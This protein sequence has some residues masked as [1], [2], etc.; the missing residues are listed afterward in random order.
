ML[1]QSTTGLEIKA[2]LFSGNK[3]PLP[4][5]RY[6]S[7]NNYLLVFSASLHGPTWSLP[8]AKCKA[9]LF[10]RNKNLL[11]SNVDHSS[12]PNY[13]N[14][15]D[16]LHSWCEQHISGNSY[17]NGQEEESSLVDVLSPQWPSQP[18]HK[19]LIAKILK[20]DSFPGKTRVLLWDSTGRT[21][22]TADR[23]SLS[24]HYH[25]Y[26]ATGYI[27]PLFAWKRHSEPV[28]EV[29]PNS[30]IKISGFVR[31]ESY[32]EVELSTTD[33]QFKFE[34]LDDSDARIQDRNVTAPTVPSAPL[35]AHS[36]AYAYPT[37][38]IDHQVGFQPPLPGQEMHM[39]FSQEIAVSTRISVNCPEDSPI[40]TLDD[41][42]QSGP[43]E[44]FLIQATLVTILPLPS[45]LDS[46]H[47]LLPYCHNCTH[48]TASHRPGCAGASSDFSPRFR[49]I[50]S[51]S[52]QILSVEICGS[53]AWGFF[54]L[55]QEEFDPT[56]YAN[57]ILELEKEIGKQSK[58]LV[59]R[60]TD[61]IS[62]Q[63]T[64][65][66]FGTVFKP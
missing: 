42:L 6:L 3:S 60:D 44:P 51:D 36:S 18:T 17:Q 9:L 12:V 59:L 53:L 10:D 7:E 56:V 40:S 65:R 66:I 24:R 45:S 55:K 63:T 54:N 41:A 1:D 16:D 61:E 58:F 52:T 30:W 21:N 46:I 38:P 20:V 8:L 25:K 32:G 50:L 34:L 11:W 57:A 64:H 14:Q 35:L 48:T 26:P 13:Q 2:K 28:R 33:K 31:K 62:G 23:M 49:L 43:D 15:L 5:S 29:K 22:A 19:S 39:D 37:P 47:T 27:A 4:D